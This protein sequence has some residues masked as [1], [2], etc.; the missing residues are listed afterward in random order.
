MGIPGYSFNLPQP[1]ASAPLPLPKVNQ[2][3]SLNLNYATKDQLFDEEEEFKENNTFSKPNL[4]TPVKEKLSVR[5]F[6]DKIHLRLKSNSDDVT[7]E[8]DAFL[9][10]SQENFAIIS[11]ELRS[12]KASIESYLQE[13]IDLEIEVTDLFQTINGQISLFKRL[14]NP[15]EEDISFIKN[16]FVEFNLNIENFNE[17]INILNKKAAPLGLRKISLISTIEINLPAN[18]LKLFQKRKQPNIS[19]ILKKYYEPL[20][21]A[22]IGY[23]TD[24]KDLLN[25]PEEIKSFEKLNLDFENPYFQISSKEEY[26]QFLSESFLENLNFIKAIS[27]TTLEKI[28]ANSAIRSAML[29]AKTP[30]TKLEVDEL[31]LLIVNLMSKASLQAAS[32]SIPLLGKEWGKLEITEEH[33]G[34]VLAL[35]IN[36]RIISF[37]NQGVTEESVNRL[38]KNNKRLKALTP[39][40]FD[41]L[42]RKLTSIVNLAL[43]QQGIVQAGISINSLPFIH[44]IFSST[45]EKFGLMT[46]FNQSFNDV[47]FD[48]AFVAYF[49]SKMIDLL[50]IGNLLNETSKDQV[51]K[52]FENITMNGPYASLEILAEQLLLELQNEV[53]LNFKEASND[54]LEM[55]DLAINLAPQAFL[56]DK[57][58]YQGITIPLI[59]SSEFLSDKAIKEVLS[60]HGIKK[61]LPFYQQAI[62]DL[63]KNNNYENLFDSLLIHPQLANIRENSL[64]LTLKEIFILIFRSL[65]DQDL[66]IEESL[67]ISESTIR[68]LMKLEFAQT[69]FKNSPSK[70]KVVLNYFIKRFQNKGLSYLKSV[71]LSKAILEFLISE[72]LFSNNLKDYNSI[73]D[74]IDGYLLLTSSFLDL[75]LIKKG[76]TKNIGRKILSYSSH[77]FNEGSLNISIRNELTEDELNFIKAN[78]I[79]HLKS[80]EMISLSDLLYN[81][82]FML[83]LLK[84]E[85]LCFGLPKE[86]APILAPFIPLFSLNKAKKNNHWLNKNR[87]RKGLI[88]RYKSPNNEIAYVAK[89]ITDNL[90]FIESEN[91]NYKNFLIYL[92]SL[93]GVNKKE[94]AKLLDINFFK[95]CLNLPKNEAIEE[96]SFSLNLNEQ[97]QRRVIPDNYISLLEGHDEKIKLSIRKA[98]EDTFLSLH[99]TKNENHFKSEFID[100]LSDSLDENQFEKLKVKIE[101]LKLPK[102]IIKEILISH[103]ILT[104]SKI[105]KLSLNEIKE[106]RLL[107]DSFF[108]KSIH[109]TNEKKLSLLLKADLTNLSFL[110]RE[111]ISEILKKFSFDLLKENIFDENNLDDFL[112]LQLSALFKNVI[113]NEKI[114]IITEQFRETMQAMK[115]SI[116]NQIE[117]LVGEA[118]SS[119]YKKL[120]TQGVLDTMQNSMNV[121]FDLFLFSE[122]LNSNGKKVLKLIQETLLNDIGINEYSKSE[123]IDLL[124]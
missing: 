55:I 73:F 14:K 43:L 107:A 3:S 123:T 71:H 87:L 108:K 88:K 122:I 54:V 112:I 65:I 22:T 48:K 75:S 60:E 66:S 31:Q 21:N 80:G 83:P 37:I 58:I 115:L 40:I 34:V 61:Y 29:E 38:I 46:S 1:D 6:V 12:Y 2:P 72:K 79:V 52:V 36:Q 89:I 86:L 81:T 57:K 105:K 47:F 102:F 120:I 78:E 19:E 109:I 35:A 28:L 124:I 41:F 63:Y 106:L 42:V 101:T 76:Y 84:K 32:I 92:E 119:N 97:I 45:L 39:N 30:L 121:N 118:Q 99:A 5:D 67:G 98:L 15:E 59:S 64:P 96:S 110:N 77:Y 13:W 62:L 16:L 17:R 114:K 95:S 90:P 94:A 50:K 4:F 117:V 27:S 49:E 18:Q 69:A 53:S 91:L 10:E 25:I 33:I 8:M 116:E 11:S 44:K 24:L 26:H 103:L 85:L 100:K 104:I 23:M 20:H 111:E 7:K 82:T 51:K 56:T 93:T 9:H 74:C 68:Y 70:I 113:S